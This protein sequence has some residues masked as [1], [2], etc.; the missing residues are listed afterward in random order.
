MIRR[1][2]ILVSLAGLLAVAAFA[3]GIDNSWWRHP[4]EGAPSTAAVAAPA[5]TLVAQAPA[6]APVPV[7]KPKVQSVSDTVEVTGNAASVNE[8]KLL[9]RVVGYLDSIHFED[10][11]LVRKGDRL[12]TVQQDQYKAQLQQAQAQL[13]LAQAQRDEILAVVRLYRALGGGWETGAEP[14]PA[15]GERP[16]AGAQPATGA[17]AY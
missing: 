2:T 1:R 13:Q 16:S 7:A 5:D 10:G 4:T 11:A 9:A 3:V 17:R 14:R 6:A 8:V 12:F 15:T